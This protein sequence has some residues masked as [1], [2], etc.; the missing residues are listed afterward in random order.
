MM[1]SAQDKRGEIPSPDMAGVYFY[2]VCKRAI[3]NLTK[4]KRGTEY[5]TRPWG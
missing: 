2:D 4:G 5:Y 1:L 3:K